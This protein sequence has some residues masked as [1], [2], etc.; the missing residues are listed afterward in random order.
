VAR[1]L[2]FAA[3]FA[4]LFGVPIAIMAI[5]GEFA[6][7]ESVVRRQ[8]TREVLF[9][10]AY[11]NR[12][13]VYKFRAAAARRPRV[14]TLGSSRVMQ[15]RA[16]MFTTPAFLNA[17]GAVRSSADLGTFLDALEPTELRVLLVGLDPWWFNED[18]VERPAAPVYSADDNA[19]NVVQHH[20]RDVY[21]DIRSGKITLDRA[22]RH[23]WRN[24][25][26][27]TALMYGN[28]FRPDGSYQ[29][30]LAQPAMTR[31]DAE[32][33]QA[34]RD[35][36]AAGQGLFTWGDRVSPDTVRDVA[37]LIANARRRGIHVVPFLPP[38]APS[39]WR[40]MTASGHYRYM[41]AAVTRLGQ[42]CADFGVEI[43]DLSDPAT[44]G[45]GD[46][47]FLDGYHGSERV[48]AALLARLAERDRAVGDV[49]DA[50]TLHRRV[51]KGGRFTLQP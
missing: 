12:A 36:V 34:A 49:A 13:Q 17:G 7:A 33:I 6:T 35:Q 48:Y 23:G 15:F 16:S 24:S 14:M 28:G 38:F 22:R 43:H 27:L 19:L 37:A 46:D 21:S 20:W 40:D 47:E 41:G 51:S 1:V 50:V 2:L 44:L 42:A 11:A 29:Y 25:V 39:V 4:A 8:A 3:P 18:R 10:Q 26:G 30:D 45:F 31:S 9:G 32:R 5:T